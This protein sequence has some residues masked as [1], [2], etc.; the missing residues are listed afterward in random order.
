LDGAEALYRKS[1]AIKEK[2]GRLEGMA[3]A[4]GNLGLTERT[5]GDV[6]QARESFTRSRELY[7]VG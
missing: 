2:L 7:T 6:R 4:Y 1:L 5:R 3:I